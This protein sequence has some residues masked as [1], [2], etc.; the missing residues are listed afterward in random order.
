MVHE[1]IPFL[2]DVKWLIYLRTL[3]FRLYYRWKKCLAVSVTVSLATCFCQNKLDGKLWTLSLSDLNTGL[4][5]AF[6]LSIV[7]YPLNLLMESDDCF[8]MM[9]RLYATCFVCGSFPLPQINFSWIWLY[10][11]CFSAMFECSEGNLFWNVGDFSSFRHT[12][13]ECSTDIFSWTQ[14]GKQSFWSSIWAVKFFEP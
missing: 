11:Y 10:N 6:D 14:G 3:K 8:F 9:L 12:C 13:K 4:S 7:V 1:F 2:V 5:F